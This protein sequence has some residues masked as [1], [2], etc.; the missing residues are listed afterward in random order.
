MKN[1]FF[2]WK[3]DSFDSEILGYK[4]AKIETSK[5]GVNKNEISKEVSRLIKDLES[6]L[7]Y[8]ATSRVSS[9]N[10]FLIQALEKKGFHLVDGLIALSTNISGRVSQDYK[11]ILKADYNDL[12]QLKNIA[13]EI[14]SGLTRYYHDPYISDDKSRAV[15]RSWIENSLNGKVAD[16]VLVCKENSIVHG[17]ITLSKKGQVPL[18][19]VSEKARGRG[20]GKA[21]LGSALDIF[22]KWR[23]ENVRIET[24]MSNIPAL[25]LYQSQGFNI[26][27]SYF[28]LAWT[29]E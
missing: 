9:D 21:L 24:Q 28:T 2:N 11:N 18:I 29:K 5:L 10:F 22:K 8:Y 20:V 14:F 17:F 23:I 12:N 3:M 27:S 7:I 25:S 6:N 26:T 1:Q 15:Y 16:L 13:G 4:V 19:G